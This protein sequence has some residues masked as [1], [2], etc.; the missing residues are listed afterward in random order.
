MRCIFCKQISDD[1]KSIE[2]IIP[3]SLGNNDHVLSKGIV[4]DSCNQYFAVKIE[5]PVLEKPYFISVRHR[6]FIKNKK[7]RIPNERVFMAGDSNVFINAN[8]GSYSI[9]IENSQ[10]IKKIINNDVSSLIIPLYDSPDS[11]DKD[12]S[13][14]ICKMALECLVYKGKESYEWLDEVTNKPELDDLR[15][16]CKIWK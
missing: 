3:E 10:T 9:V 7:N 4:C 14:F 13:R 15:Y 8:G 5:K 12:I 11:T 1:S 2:H 16:L 6:N